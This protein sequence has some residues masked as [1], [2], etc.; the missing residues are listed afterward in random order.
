MARAY[1]YLFVLL[2]FHVLCLQFQGN[3]KS[4]TFDRLPSLTLMPL[5]LQLF[6]TLYEQD[7]CGS[8]AAA[9]II[10][11]QVYR[12]GLSGERERELKGNKIEAVKGT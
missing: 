4:E 11:K 7:S 8:M 2:P 9:I 6:C 3:S 12:Q 10:T 1:S 5:Q